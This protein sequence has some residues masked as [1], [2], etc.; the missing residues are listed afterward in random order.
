M[1]IDFFV[2]NNDKTKRIYFLVNPF[3]VY[4]LKYSKIRPL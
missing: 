1:V 4:E 2:F 3:F